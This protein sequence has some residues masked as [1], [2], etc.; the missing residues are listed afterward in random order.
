MYL[1]HEASTVVSRFSLSN[2]KV[3]N[4]LLP[5]VLFVMSACGQTS[6][7]SF[8]LDQEP[9][10]KELCL[11]IKAWRCDCVCD[12]LSQNQASS[13]MI[14]HEWSRNG[15]IKWSNYASHVLFCIGAAAARG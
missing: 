12:A 4:F 5:S 10:T 7:M 6:G 13:Y 11:F 3:W 15:V 14:S 9:V 1:Y 2:S 8:A